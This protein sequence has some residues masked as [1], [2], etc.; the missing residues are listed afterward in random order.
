[1]WLL[2]AGQQITIKPNSS[3]DYCLKSLIDDLV[4]ILRDSNDNFDICVHDHEYIG[5]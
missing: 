5:S 1:M 3:T 4:P 2:S